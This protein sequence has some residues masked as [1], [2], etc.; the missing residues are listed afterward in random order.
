MKNIWRTWI[1]WI[2]KNLWQA[3]SQRLIVKTI[4]S[5]FQPKWRKFRV[6]VKITKKIKSKEHSFV[7]ESR[8]RIVLTIWLIQNYICETLCNCLIFK[9]WKILCLQTFYE[10]LLHIFRDINSKWNLSSETTINKGHPSLILDQVFNKPNLWRN[11]ALRMN[12]DHSKEFT[13][14]I[15]TKLEVLLESSSRASIN[16]K[17]SKLLKFNGSNLSSI[18]EFQ[19]KI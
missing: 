15:L 10:S 18:E 14:I 6:H 9:L 2:T 5:I 13:W 17:S 16:F 8:Q 19:P 3:Q 1:T 4:W 11:Y 7:K 12:E